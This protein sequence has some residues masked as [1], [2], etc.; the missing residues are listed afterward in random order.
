MMNRSHICEFKKTH[1]PQAQWEG[2]T[3]LL[4]VVRSPGTPVKL[5]LRY[6]T[7][8]GDAH[9]RQHRTNESE[10][11]WLYVPIADPQAATGQFLDGQKILR[12][13][14]WTHTKQG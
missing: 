9:A 4:L 1:Q 7:Y 8:W 2:T 6:D 14:L 13:F 5:Q 12:S 3:I 11:E 10:D